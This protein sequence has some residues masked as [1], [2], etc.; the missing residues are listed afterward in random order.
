MIDFDHDCYVCD[1]CGVDIKSGEMRVGFDIDQKAIH[2]KC[3]AEDCIKSCF[4]CIMAI[5]KPYH[6]IY[7]GEFYKQID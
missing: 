4:A 7:K 2:R 5:D 1:L 6:S 3:K